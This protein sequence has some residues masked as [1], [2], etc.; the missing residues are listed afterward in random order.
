MFFGLS[1]VDWAVRVV[2]QLRKWFELGR[3]TTQNA[4]DEA[5]LVQTSAKTKLKQLRRRASDS[6]RPLCFLLC[7]LISVSCCAFLLQLLPLLS[8]HLF[9]LLVHCILS[10]RDPKLSSEISSSFLSFPLLLTF[11]W[12]VFLSFPGQLTHVTVT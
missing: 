11:W 6:S 8:S 1:C 5:R 2:A 9:L 4:C 7:V 10:Y 12:S 3:R